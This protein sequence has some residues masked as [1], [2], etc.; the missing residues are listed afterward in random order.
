MSSAKPPRWWGQEGAG[1]LGPPQDK[2]LHSLVFREGFAPKG[3]ES[4]RSEELVRSRKA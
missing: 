1:R 4:S 2:A 3:P